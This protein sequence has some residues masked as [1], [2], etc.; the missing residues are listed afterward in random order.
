MLIIPAIDLHRGKCV[1]LRRG[2]R[3]QETVYSDNPAAVAQ[4]WYEAGA[5]RLHVVDLDGAFAGKPVNSPVIAQVAEAVDIP[6]Q[7]GGGMRDRATVEKAFELGISRVIVGTAAVEQPDLIRELVKLYG[8]RIIVGI[9]ARDGLAAVRG[10]VKGSERRAVELAKE[11]ESYG[12]AE[13]IY[14]DISR[15]GMLKGPNIEAMREMAAAL[16]IPVIASGGVSSMDDLLKLQ[17]LEVL[18]VAGVIVG[19][20]LYS[21]QINLKD[22][23]TKLEQLGRLGGA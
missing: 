10:W 20:A 5:K 6:V 11:M 7:L 16:Q 13:I 19:Q 22:A 9:D 15:D 3:E 18:G 21:N 8:T 17:T 12:V 2:E 4:A 14:T 23:I 1:R